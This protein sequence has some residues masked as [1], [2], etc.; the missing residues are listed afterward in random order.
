MACEPGNHF[1]LQ[2]SIVK[3]YSFLGPYKTRSQLPAF[4]IWFDVLCIPKGIS[5]SLIHMWVQESFQCKNQSE[6]ICDF[7]AFLPDHCADNL[8]LILGNHLPY[9]RWIIWKFFIFWDRN[10][11]TMNIHCNN[12]ARDFFFCFRNV[13]LKIDIYYKTLECE[14]NNME[15]KWKL[16]KLITKYLNKQSLTSCLWESIIRYFYCYLQA[17]RNTINHLA[18]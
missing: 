4:L 1:E 10:F 7:K 16:K 9:W 2:V 6:F 5:H 17:L 18:L 14:T 8:E 3:P 15:R 11:I 12:I 13:S